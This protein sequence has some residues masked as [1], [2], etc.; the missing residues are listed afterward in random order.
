MYSIIPKNLKI[1]YQ[2]YMKVHGN[3]NHMHVEKQTALVTVYYNNNL[4]TSISKSALAHQ[5]FLFTF[6]FFFVSRLLSGV[7]VSELRMP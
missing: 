3:V 5:N 2:H 6:F 7:S 1:Q 4:V